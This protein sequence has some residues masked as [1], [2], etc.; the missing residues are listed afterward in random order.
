MRT[1]VAG[2][3][4]RPEVYPGRTIKQVLAHIAGL[5]DATIALPALN[6]P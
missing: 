1:L 4:R 5:D 2:I 3:D 6:Q